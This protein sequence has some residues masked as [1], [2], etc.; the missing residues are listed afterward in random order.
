MTVP[1]QPPS[2]WML[3]AL[4]LMTE[5]APAQAAG[6]A[7]LVVTQAAVPAATLYV[8]K[9][10]VDTVTGDGASPEALKPLL[11]L[12]LAFCGILFYGALASQWSTYIHALYQLR[13]TD[14]VSRKVLEKAVTVPYTY[15]ETPAYHDTLH[16]AQQQALYKSAQLLSGVSTLMLQ[17]T[18]LVLVGG[19]MAAY[20]GPF[21]ALLIGVSLPLL[22]VKGYFARKSYVEETRLSALERESS[23]LHLVLTGVTFAKEVRLLGFAA[24][25]IEAYSR[26]RTTLFSRRR[27]LQNRQNRYTLLVTVLEIGAIGGVFL[28]LA[29]DTLAGA[30]TPGLFVL[31]LQGFPKLQSATRQSVQAFVHLYQLR[32]FVQHLFAFLDLHEERAPGTEPFPQE[33]EALHVRNVTFAYPE[34]KRPALDG[35]SLSCRRGEIV[36]LVGENGSGKSTLVKLLG[37]LYP[38]DAGHIALGQTPLHAIA[39]DAFQRHS[40]FLFQDFE[41]YFLTVEKN[42]R[43]GADAYEDGDERLRRAAVQAG[44]WPFIEALP[45]GLSTRLGRSFLRGTQLSGGQW[46]KLALARVFYRDADLV[47]LDEPTSALDALAETELYAALRLW[48]RDRMILLITH[49]PQQLRQADRIYV[50]RDGR[51]VEHGTFDALVAQ[52]GYFFTL[53]EAHV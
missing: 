6:Y 13:L 14:H 39:P 24:A 41:K 40:I 48:G 45:E 1:P 37:Q 23:Y 30:L 10:L 15:Y 31:F 12:V 50:M 53:F 3:R 52:R 49:R 26:L 43:L 5:A 36:A 28:I 9:A 46:Q 35:V 22:A 17:G 51:I 47:V 21:A 7:L 18:T 38:P 33:A 2:R 44:A 8:V 34:A 29:R 16:L 25:F 32:L 27:A 4:R 11:L 42:I 19:M 20:Y